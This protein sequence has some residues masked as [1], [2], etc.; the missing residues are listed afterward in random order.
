M[1]DQLRLPH[2]PIPAPGVPRGFDL[3]HKD[4]DLSMTFENLLYTMSF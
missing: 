2:P 1:Y 3:N 4:Q